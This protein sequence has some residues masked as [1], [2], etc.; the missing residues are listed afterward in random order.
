M[1]IALID[2]N[3]FY[4]SCEQLFQPRLLGKPVVV[5]SNNDGCV[6][7]RSAEAKALGIPMGAPWHTLKELARRH[8]VVALS[9]NYALYGDM[10]AR[11]MRVLSRF[12][13]IQEVY[14]IDECFLDLT[15]DPAP[16]KCG[17]IIHG[18]VRRLTGIGVGVGLGPTK[19]L[20]KFANHCAK[21]RPEF[22]GVCPLHEMPPAEID[23]LLA[24]AP[25]GAV[26]GVGGRLAARLQAMDYHTALDL[27]RAS[28][29]RIRRCFSVTLERTVRE[30]NG[31]RCLGLMAGPD[32][33]KQIF[34]SRSFGQL[35]SD[36]SPLEEAVAAYGTRAAE[37]LRQQGLVAGSVG[38]ILRTNP[39][40]KDLPQYERGL[41]LTIIPTDDT[42]LI[43]QAALKCLR[44][45][46]RPGFAYQKAG[47]LLT[48]LAPTEQ[49]Q[50][51]LF[52]D[53]ALQRKSQ[54]LM[55]AMDRINRSMGKGTVKLLVEGND[56]RWAM[57]A[58]RRTPRYTTR[59][60]ELALAKS[61]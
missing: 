24:W 58:E 32:T 30:L 26:W 12:S 60:D 46:Y 7:A 53:P 51:T 34:S 50:A 8:S 36:L 54:A 45:I 13:P 9:S 31:E 33:R 35:I 42:R 37:K 1:P 38:V 49:R 25:V 47:V 41:N 52:E 39:F 40:R 10:S 3:N 22:D 4:A 18:E 21:K 59:L 44:A 55:E 29:S 19:T 48:D 16:T 5:L 2:G 43:V 11:V 15:G 23:R 28:P 20:A 57:R 27:K 14:S 56:Q 61:R 6:V 17:R